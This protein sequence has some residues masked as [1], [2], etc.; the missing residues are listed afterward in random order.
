MRTVGLVIGHFDFHVE[1]AELE[2]VALRKILG[3]LW[4]FEFHFCIAHL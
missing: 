2:E 1:C 3:K 4:Q